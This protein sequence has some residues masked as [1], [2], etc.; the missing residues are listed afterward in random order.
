VWRLN[1][2]VDRTLIRIHVIG[3]VVGAIDW[4]CAGAPVRFPEPENATPLTPTGEV[5]NG[6]HISQ[7]AGKTPRCRRESKC[8]ACPY[9]R[10]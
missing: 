7:L 8:R 9:L 3:P 5:V 1:D 4:A 6:S 2:R 10:T